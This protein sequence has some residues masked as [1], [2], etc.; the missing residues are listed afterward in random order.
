M[1]VNK[2][3][4][5]IYEIENFISIE[6]QSEVL[7]SILLSGESLWNKDESNDKDSYWE[8]KSTD[9]KFL[10]SGR[11]L[12]DIFYKRIQMLYESYV[13]ITGINIQRYKINDY[14]NYHIDNHEGHLKNGWHMRYGIVLYYNDDYIGGE[15]HYKDLDIIY[16]PKARSLIMHGG[17]I[18]HGTKPVLGGSTRYFSTCFVKGTKE[19]PVILNKKLFSEIEETDGTT[20]R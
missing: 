4:P 3:F 19:K 18:E 9:P 15:L 10:H 5:D 16:K 8:N 12:F 20:Y 17:N 6:E 13:E 11:E 2:I 7:N 1:K 14:L